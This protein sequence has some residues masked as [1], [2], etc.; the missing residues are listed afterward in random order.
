[1]YASFRFSPQFCTDL[2]RLS[3]V[4]L[5]LLYQMTFAMLGLTSQ[6]SM[7]RLEEASLRLYVPDGYIGTHLH[8]RLS[9][10]EYVYDKDHIATLQA[11]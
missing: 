4:E 8:T 9:D 10:R 11:E 5:Y 2:S 6:F 1:M 3:G 7:L